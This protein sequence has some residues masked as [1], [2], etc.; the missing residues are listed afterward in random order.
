MPRPKRT[1]AKPKTITV[2]SHHNSKASQ[3]IA[4]VVVDGFLNQ[5]DHPTIAKA[6]GTSVETMRK[7]YKH[8]ELPLGYP[9]ND[10]DWREDV[11]QFMQVAIW[12]GT[13]RLAETGMDLMPL[14]K[15]CVGTAI[16]V[17]KHSLMQGNPTSFSVS[18]TMQIDQ[19]ALLDR[20][21]SG[22]S[23]GASLRSKRPTSDSPQNNPNAI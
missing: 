9:D 4:D 7:Y 12:K 15:I 22:N 18:A 23:I 2:K 6:S 5:R 10:D 14:D 11:K 13:K 19:K 8:I 1:P 21:S 3:H 20:I 17:D 16:L